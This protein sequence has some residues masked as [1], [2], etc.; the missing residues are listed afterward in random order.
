MRPFIYAALWLVIGGAFVGTPVGEQARECPGET[1]PSEVL[2]WAA[3]WPAIF[4]MAITL[5]DVPHSDCKEGG[6]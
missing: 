2:L 4:G 1:I 5:G 6:K 3:A